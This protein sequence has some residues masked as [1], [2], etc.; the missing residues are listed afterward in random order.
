MCVCVSVCVRVCVCVCECVCTCLCVCMSVCVCVSLCVC[1]CVCENV[2]VASYS[3]L[4]YF[5]G[6]CVAIV[7]GLFYYTLGNLDP[8][9][10]SLSLKNIHLATLRCENLSNYMVLKKSRH[11]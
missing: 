4:N 5:H 11:Q 3:Y 7:Y 2:D 1:M 9:L 6:C 10:W 8:V